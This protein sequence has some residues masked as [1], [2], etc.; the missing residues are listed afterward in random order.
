MTLWICTR[1]DG[2]Q[3]AHNGLREAIADTLKAGL[4][5]P[6]RNADHYPALQREIDK[7]L[8]ALED[9]YNAP[10]PDRAAR[11]AADSGVAQQQPF[12]PPR[13]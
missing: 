8:S 13:M 2:R 3:P 5:L 9:L 11:L 10:S 7:V 6:N 12:F 1:P 4:G